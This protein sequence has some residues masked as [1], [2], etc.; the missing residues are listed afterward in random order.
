MIFGGKGRWIILHFTN[1]KG[2]HLGRV[3]HDPTPQPISPE[4]LPASAFAEQGRRQGR[5]SLAAPEF[6]DGFLWCKTIKSSIFWRQLWLVFGGVGCSKLRGN[7]LSR[8]PQT[9]A[10]S[11]VFL[12]AELS[13][14]SSHIRNCRLLDKLPASP[15]QMQITSAHICVFL[16]PLHPHRRRAKIL[17]LFQCNSHR[18][19]GRVR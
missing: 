16:Y 5:S 15:S 9:L 8:Y 2:R 10:Q 13:K 17:T 3:F 1:L 12:V 14:V 11:L 18:P 7:L 6:A 19:G 4:H